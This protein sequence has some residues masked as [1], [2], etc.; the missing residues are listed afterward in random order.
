M[1]NNENYFNKVISSRKFFLSEDLHYREEL[2]NI[3]LRSQTEN[4]VRGI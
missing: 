1:F 4:F 2:F 3:N